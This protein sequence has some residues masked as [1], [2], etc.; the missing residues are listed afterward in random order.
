[1]MPCTRSPVE[2]A[3]SVMRLMHIVVA[4]FFAVV[5]FLT[6]MLPSFSALTSPLWG[7]R[8]KLADSQ[9]QR[10]QRARG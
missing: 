10:P 3:S 2:L 5:S 9:W 8:S 1:M 7:P 4:F 6:L